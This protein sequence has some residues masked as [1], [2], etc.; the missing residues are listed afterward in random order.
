LW[1]KAPSALLPERS[2]LNT[3]TGK[4]AAA[5]GRL[6]TNAIVAFKQLKHLQRKLE[7][8]AD[9]HE[10]GFENASSRKH[11]FKVAVDDYVS[12][13]RDIRGLT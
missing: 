2:L 12:E 10:V 6:G 1:W 13:L 8:Q 3:T 11:P 5:A 4:A 9:S 7:D